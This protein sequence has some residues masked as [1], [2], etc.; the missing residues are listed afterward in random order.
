MAEESVYRTL[1]EFIID[2]RAYAAISTVA[3]R[4]LACLCSSAFRNW[5]PAPLR[6]Y[7]VRFERRAMLAKLV[8]R[9]NGAGSVDLLS[10]D[11]MT[12]DDIAEAEEALPVSA[13]V[14]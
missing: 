3:H 8:G 12:F 5:L 13:S 4:P 6:P 7:E 10:D 2:G 1:S 14:V 9:T 11:Q